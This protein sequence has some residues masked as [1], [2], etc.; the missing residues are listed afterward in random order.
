MSYPPKETEIDT[1]PNSQHKLQ[2]SQLL[3]SSTVSSSTTLNEA[4]AR[5]IAS[6]IELPYSHEYGNSNSAKPPNS[7][8]ASSSQ[9]TT[10][11][12]P[13]GHYYSI[14]KHEIP[15]NSYT[16]GNLVSDS[17]SPRSTTTTSLADPQHPTSNSFYQHHSLELPSPSSSTSS[18]T[19][20]TNLSLFG[21]YSPSPFP[22]LPNLSFDTPTI[23]PP[24]P[25]P[26]AWNP[27]W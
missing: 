6:N 11:E 9:L 2:K 8:T 4:I 22:L 3:S 26:S 5:N 14:S 1:T 10:S 12:R 18:Q 23:F 7:S 17:V 21:S 20:K 13:S 15:P 16:P 25:P 27:F 24:T 19:S